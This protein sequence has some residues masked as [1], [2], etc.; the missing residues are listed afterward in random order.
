MLGSRI[1]ACAQAF[2]HRYER[3]LR[4]EELTTASDI[5][6]AR[7]IYL[8]GFAFAV[9]QI[10]N[11]A[12]MTMSYGEWTLDH[13]ISVASVGLV[14]ALTQA[15]RWYKN[16]PTYALVYSLFIFM[17]IAASAMVDQ[18]GINSS[19]LPILIAGILL[20]GF[21]SDWVWV[22]IYS[23]FA[24]VFVFML[25]LNAAG[26]P[27][28]GVMDAAAIGIRIEQR[29]IQAALAIVLVSAIVCLFTVNL[30][31]LFAT[32]E[33]KIAIAEQAE[34]A[35]SQFLA[36]MSH[37]L[38][39]P[40]NGVIGMA[41]LLSR[42]QLD[43]D[44]RQY[45]DIVNGCSTGLVTIINDVLDISKLDAGK[46]VLQHTGFDLAV[47]L[48][49]LIDLHRPSAMGKGINLGLTYDPALPTRFFSDE[50]RLRQVINN[51]IGN[52]IKFTEQG[53]VGVHVRGK[54]GAQGFWN[55]SFYV[56]DTGL[57]IDPEHQ[58]RIFGR[59]EQIHEGNTTTYAGTGL[60]LA[61]SRDLVRVFGGELTLA[62]EPGVGTTFGFVIPIR[63]DRRAFPVE[64]VGRER[65]AP[66]RRSA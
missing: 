12:F 25:Y 11:M 8:I 38:R 54:P 2:A 41:Q 55:L 13:T 4:F 39:T 58:E 48:D 29:A 40:L 63:V 14:I 3:F 10:P 20:N 59:F 56:Q 24:L 6:K 43:A 45:V 17:G 35:K 37:E 7:A 47:M 51:L 46:V 44:Q 57:G 16:F 52:A 31:R 42:T 34:M 32:L 61:I 36:N 19:L 28:G 62:S 1:I 5:I 53:S 64:P 21:I 26:A 60:G 65:R 66:L 49:S 30:H 18:T 33:E 9:V 27:A 23:G 22:L 50:S 15:L